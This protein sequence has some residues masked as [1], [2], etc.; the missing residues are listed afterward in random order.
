MRIPSEREGGLYR[1]RRE[2]AKVRGP[3]D[4]PS[5]RSSSRLYA[6]VDPDR[7][8]DPAV[9]F[10]TRCTL[11]LLAVPALAVGGDKVAAT[12]NGESVTVAEL[13]AAAGDLPVAEAPP[14]AAQKKQQ[15]ADVLQLL[16]DDK[17]VRQYLRQ[18]GPKV[19]AADV[20]RQFAA[21]EKG[22][23]SQGKTVDDYLKEGGQTA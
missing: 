23:K 12:I 9:P 22:L 3:G 7:S 14:T 21:L 13:D 11:F 4:S 8:E 18:H 16:I 19:D 10:R 17:L 1:G 20:D 2:N 5:R 6:P 15:R